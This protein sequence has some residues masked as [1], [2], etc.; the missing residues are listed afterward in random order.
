MKTDNS[1]A[2]IPVSELMTKRVETLSSG[3][4]VQEAVRLMLD[5]NLTTIPIVD[6]GNQSVGI[7]SRSD[8]TEMFLQEDHELSQIVDA[9]WLSAERLN[10][11]LDTGNVKLV[12]ELMTHDVATIRSDQTVVDA[13]R[14]M[15][16]NQVHHLPVVDEDAAV[17]GIVSAFDVVSL[18][19]KSGS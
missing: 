18:V 8:L 19:A 11:A 1:I 3:D 14:L 9:Q 4:T 13:C 10:R 2:D 15:E 5:S 17:I 6:S 7:L 12:K 16:K